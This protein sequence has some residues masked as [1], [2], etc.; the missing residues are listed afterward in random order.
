M[1]G[2]YV[3]N[4]SATFATKAHIDSRKKVLVKQQYVLHMS[5]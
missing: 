4:S 3:Y 1:R 2:P 5:S